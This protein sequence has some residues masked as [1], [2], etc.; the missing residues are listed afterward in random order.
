MTSKGDHSLGEGDGL[1]ALIKSRK[2]S[3]AMILLNAQL[4]S[5]SEDERRR[6]RAAIEALGFVAD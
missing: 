1:E 4:L 3:E 5:G 2:L 6:A